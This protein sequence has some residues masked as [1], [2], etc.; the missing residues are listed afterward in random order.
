MEKY[1]FLNKKKNGIRF[2]SIIFGFIVKGYGNYMLMIYLI[3]LFIRIIIYNN[4][5]TNFI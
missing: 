2:S 5:D 4:K 3:F 1:V